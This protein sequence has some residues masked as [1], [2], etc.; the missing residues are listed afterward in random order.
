MLI[1]GLRIILDFEL[2]HVIELSFQKLFNISWKR[3]KEAFPI[4]VNCKDN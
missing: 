4:T 3:H 2:S 1:S